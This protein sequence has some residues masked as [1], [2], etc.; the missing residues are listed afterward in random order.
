MSRSPIDKDCG[1]G[2][3]WIYGTDGGDGSGQ[4][5]WIDSE[6]HDQLLT[7]FEFEQNNETCQNPNDQ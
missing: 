4:T 2:R 1:R 5:Q 7:L 3:E 6:T